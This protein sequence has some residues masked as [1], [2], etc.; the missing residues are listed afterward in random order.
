MNRYILD[1]EDRIRVL[2]PHDGAEAALEVY[3]GRTVSFFDLSDIE[4]ACISHGVTEA[5]GGDALRLVCTDAL[6]GKKHELYVPTARADYPA[7]WD[8]LRKA[9]PELTLGA[10]QT[11]VKE[12]CNHD[13]KR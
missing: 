6:F 2:P 7:F 5:Q 10:E 11:Y 12:T 4:A 13:G 1:P 8:A 3:S 9:A